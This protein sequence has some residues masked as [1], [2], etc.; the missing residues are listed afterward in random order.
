MN[1]QP[2]NGMPPD[3]A[4]QT[5]ETAL[6]GLEEI[7]RRLEGGDLTLEESIRHFQEGM[8]LVRFCAAKLDEAERRIEQLIGEAGGE[9]VARPFPFDPDADL[10]G[11]G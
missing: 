5:F 1:G 8:A 2:G 11:V 7:V 6:A 10:E 9:V 4:R 3:G